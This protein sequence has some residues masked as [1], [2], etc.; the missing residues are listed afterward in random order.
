VGYSLNVTTHAYPSILNKKSLRMGRKGLRGKRLSAQS[1]VATLLLGDNYRSIGTYM[2][3]ASRVGASLVRGR[4]DF[5]PSGLQPREN[6][7][8]R[9]NSCRIGRLRDLE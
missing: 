1:M 2:H 7:A 9:G 6:K 5:L 8:L 3:A 4:S